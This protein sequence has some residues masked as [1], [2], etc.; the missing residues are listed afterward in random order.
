MK[1][2]IE[3]IEERSGWI[4]VNKPA[5]ISVHNTEKGV[6][7]LSILRDQ[8]GYSLHAV[9][10]LDSPTSGVILLAKN[11]QQTQILQQCLTIATKEYTAILRGVVE[12]AE[13]NWTWRISNKGEGFRNPRGRKSD[14]VAALTSFR[15]IRSNKYLSLV[16]LKLGTGRQHQ[17]R[18]HAA[19]ANHP[20][21]FD[22]RYG[23]RRYNAKLEQRY[24]VNH[25][26]LC[27]TKLDLMINSERV[28]LEVTSPK[29][30]SL[31]L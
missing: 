5:G 15:T 20:V 23:D 22:R 2:K 7:L 25:L 26:C 28:S 12:P 19:L 17:I 29:S 18:K 1:A 24:G 6:N 31:F 27:A 21:I 8:V 16:N 14:Q 30:W 10:R 9:H 4:A 3:I 11:A 13:G